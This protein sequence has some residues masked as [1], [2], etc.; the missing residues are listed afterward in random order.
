MGKESNT[1]ISYCVSCLYVSES[2][3]TVPMKG[4]ISLPD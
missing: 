1:D 4:L 2:G 3:G